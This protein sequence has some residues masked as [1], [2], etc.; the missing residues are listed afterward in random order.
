ML[1]I[2]NI[3]KPSNISVKWN[4]KLKNRSDKGCQPKTR[5]QLGQTIQFKG[6]SKTQAIQRVIINVG[7]GEQSADP[8]QHPIVSTRAVWSVTVWSY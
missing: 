1:L 7:P 2:K 8:T 4:I 3:T 5:Q 6:F